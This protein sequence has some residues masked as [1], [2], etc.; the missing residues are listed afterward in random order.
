MLCNKA[1]VSIDRRICVDAAILLFLLSARE[2]KGTGLTYSGRSAA[3]A[4]AAGGAMPD[5]SIPDGVASNP[6]G[7]ANPAGAMVGT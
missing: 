1:A 5:G 6:G 2:I 4:A 3:G 7:G